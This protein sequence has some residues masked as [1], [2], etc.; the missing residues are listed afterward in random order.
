[1][2]STFLP[3]H[4]CIL[5]PA[6][7]PR[8]TRP[9]FYVN[10]MD[11]LRSFRRTTAGP[12]SQP[13]YHY[14]MLP[15]DDAILEVSGSNERD[16]NRSISVEHG[17]ETRDESTTSRKC[18]WPRDRYSSFFFAPSGLSRTDTTAS[19]IS[20]HSSSTAPL[21]S[22]RPSTVL[23]QNSGLPTLTLPSSSPQTYIR[24]LVL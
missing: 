16:L 5:Y 13:Q 22:C 18:H 21:S 11:S 24:T 6:R 23:S 19:D 9:H 17:T 2:A 14:R 20:A 10:P 3:Q 15:K 7:V 4:G 8:L 12:A 1:M